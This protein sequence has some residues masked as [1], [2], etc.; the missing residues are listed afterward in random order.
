M[1]PK[2]LEEAIIMALKT[3]WK[4]IVITASVLLIFLMILCSCSRANKWLGLE[5][6]NPVEEYAEDIIEF[7]TGVK[8][9]LSSESPEN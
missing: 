9:D 1:I 4:E 5:D 6:D 3:Y 2:E 7:K 8:M